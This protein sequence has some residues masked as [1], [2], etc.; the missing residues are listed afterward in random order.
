M[1]N[2]VKFVRGTAAAYAQLKQKD[3]DT[4]YFIYEEDSA[5]GQLY[6][7]SKQ[8]V[9]NN[10]TN[11]VTALAEL[12]DVSLDD[13]INDGDILTYDVSTEKWVAKSIDDI[14]LT[15]P[16][17]RTPLVF[18]GELQGEE[19]HE[20][21]LTRIV[22]GKNLGSG[23]IAVVKVKITEGKYQH[24][25]YAYDGEKWVALDGSYSAEN[26]YM[27]DGETTLEETLQEVQ[28]AVEE[29]TSAVDDIDSKI[30]EAIAQ[31]EHLSYK[32]VDDLE[33]L[34]ELVEAD[35][36]DLDRYIYLVPA[37]RS[38][39][40]DS[41][42]EY[43]V[44]NKQIEKVGN[45]DVDLSSKVD[46]KEGFDLVSNTDIT[47]LQGLAN[48]KTVA[49]PEFVLTEGGELQL[50]TVSADKIDGLEDALAS[51]EALTDIANQVSGLSDTIDE[52]S[53]TVGDLDALLEATGKEDTN[54]I[55]ELA[56]LI[57]ALSWT[58]LE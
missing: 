9:C 32:I 11:V 40:Q 55:D 47:K 56:D 14:L 53:D 50:G 1:A 22:G 29:A 8:I 34:E 16:E 43:M 57:K 10:N 13:V 6:L 38:D 15:V 33:A 30:A 7:G 5:Q 21:A 46:K 4:L 20:A 44:I 24:Y 51:S 26:I 19:T 45:W 18:S 54:V 39:G 36:D 52:L 31:V 35:E 58:E 25:A 12:T 41:Y 37:T 23:D 48:I 27:S 3:N 49:S 17:F 2:Y 42:D 28:D